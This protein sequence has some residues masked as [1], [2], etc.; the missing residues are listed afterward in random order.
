[1]KLPATGPDVSMTVVQALFVS[2]AG[3]L[4]ISLRRRRRTTQG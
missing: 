2:V 1:V 4:V 3:A